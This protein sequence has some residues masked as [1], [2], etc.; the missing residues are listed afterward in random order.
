MRMRIAA[1][2]ASLAALAASGL[3]AQDLAFCNDGPLRLRKSPALDAAVVGS[4]D[5]YE[6]VIVLEQS[7]KTASVDGFESYWY[8]IRSQA[9]LEGWAFGGYLEIFDDQA[10]AGFNGVF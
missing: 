7:A 6:K 5:T 1:L 3:A 8:R 2:V 4:V 10:R 9:G